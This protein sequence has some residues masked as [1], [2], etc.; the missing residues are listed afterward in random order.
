MVCFLTSSGHCR[1]ISRCC[2]IVTSSESWAEAF[3]AFNC[4]SK[5][6]PLD[7]ILDKDTPIHTL[8]W[9]NIDETWLIARHN[10]I[11][12]VLETELETL[13]EKWVHNECNGKIEYECKNEFRNRFRMNGSIAFEI[14][15]VPKAIIVMFLGVQELVGTRPPDFLRQQ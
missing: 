1:R 6:T 5:Q 9:Q 14:L 15:I 8:K 4:L 13:V 10:W 12:G 3:V 11:E 7:N 2:L